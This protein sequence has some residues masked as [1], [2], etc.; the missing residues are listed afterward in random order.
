MVTVNEWKIFHVDIDGIVWSS[1]SRYAIERVGG[2]QLGVSMK[3]VT[4]D[5]LQKP[6]WQVIVCLAVG[7]VRCSCYAVVIDVEERIATC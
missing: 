3:S 5:C 4:C 2:F 6:A 1:V 7:S